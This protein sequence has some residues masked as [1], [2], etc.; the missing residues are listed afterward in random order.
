MTVIISGVDAV[1]RGLISKH[2]ISDRTWVVGCSGIRMGTEVR[3]VKVCIGPFCG[4]VSKSFDYRAYGYTAQTLP[5]HNYPEC[6][7]D[8]FE[9]AETEWHC[10]D[11]G[12]S[13]LCIITPFFMSAFLYGP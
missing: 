10:G 6:G 7:C 4:T 12:G 11:I 1:M 5:V 3:A 13:L 8:L 9:F 2:R